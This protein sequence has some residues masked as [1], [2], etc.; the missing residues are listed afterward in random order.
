MKSLQY[1]RSSA[2]MENWQEFWQDAD[3]TV[4][5]CKAGLSDEFELRHVSIDARTGAVTIFYEERP[6][7]V[8][9]GV[10]VITADGTTTGDLMSD[11]SIAVDHLTN[12]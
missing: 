4:E 11:D 9:R 12:R 1:P 6:S 7:P 3:A 8:V 10:T 2:S 5:R